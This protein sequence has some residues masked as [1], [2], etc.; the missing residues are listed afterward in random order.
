MGAVSF[1]N[2]TTLYAIKHSWEIWRARS[3]N[4]F[5]RTLMCRLTL[6]SNH[7]SCTDHPFLSST[8]SEQKQKGK[9]MKSWSPDFLCWSTM[10]YYWTL[11]RRGIGVLGLPVA[12]N[13]CVLSCHCRYRN[14]KWLWETSYFSDTVWTSTYYHSWAGGFN[15]SRNSADTCLNLM[16]QQEKTFSESISVTWASDWTSPC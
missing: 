11:A 8:L 10:T 7:N 3:M 5:S 2:N 13:H 16:S 9:T 15:R 14:L 6:Y 4:L 12:A 1:I